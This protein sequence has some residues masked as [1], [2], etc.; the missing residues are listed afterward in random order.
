MGIF[1]SLVSRVK[2]PIPGTLSTTRSLPLFI[3]RMFPQN[4]MFQ[5]QLTSKFIYLSIRT[6][7]FEKD[8]QIV[9]ILSKI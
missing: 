4:E 1:N 6:G 7:R 8:T 3:E 2:D 9:Q 5:L